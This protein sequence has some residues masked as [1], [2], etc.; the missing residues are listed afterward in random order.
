M[1]SNSGS[2][3]TSSDEDE[4]VGA[5]LIPGAVG[6]L[7]GSSTKYLQDQIGIDEDGTSPTVAS[8]SE[9]Q[10]I[11]DAKEGASEKV[12]KYVEVDPLKLHADEQPKSKPQPQQG[13]VEYAKVKPVLK[14]KKAAGVEVHKPTKVQSERTWTVRGELTSNIIIIQCDVVM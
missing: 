7:E 4:P 11:A 12:P 10:S 5:T 9:A 3:D 1:A 2:D 14:V 13:S 8:I 6:E